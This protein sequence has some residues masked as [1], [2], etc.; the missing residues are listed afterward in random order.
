MIKSM[1]STLLT[2]IVFY[3]KLS[4]HLTYCGFKCNEINISTCNK[5]VNGNQLTVQFHADDL[6]V[7]YKDT[8]VLEEFLNDQR[9]DLG[10]KMKY[11]EQGGYLMTTLKSQLIKV[12]RKSGIRNVQ[13]S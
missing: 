1:Y 3:I 9:S 8:S 4:K 12:Y 6:K 5:T 13:L 11:L 2:D 10:R 7:S